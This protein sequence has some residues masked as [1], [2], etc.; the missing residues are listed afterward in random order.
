MQY[1]S[2][3]PSDQLG[4]V[5]SEQRKVVWHMRTLPHGDVAATLTVIRLAPVRPG[6][7][8]RVRVGGATFEFMVLT[9]ARPGE[10]SGVRWSDLDLDD[11]V[12]T[13]PAER[14]K[15]LREHGVPLSR[16]AVKVL[17]AARALLAARARRRRPAR[18][19]SRRG[20]PSR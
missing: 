17:D 13:V 10:V 4:P 11:A 5:L 3:N 15:A 19:R 8:A 14:M 7:Q 6:A 9:A 2:D 16:P 20:T 12:W 1:R 18:L